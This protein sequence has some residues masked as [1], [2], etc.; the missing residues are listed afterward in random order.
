MNQP[1]I[2]TELRPMPRLIDILLTLFAWVLFI[3][4]IYSGLA[5]ALEHTI[6]SEIRPFFMTLDTMT[7]YTVVALFNGIVLIGWAKYNQYRFRVERRHR[8]PGLEE[9]ELA[10]SL[11]IS[12]KLTHELGMA[13]VVTVFHDDNGDIDHIERVKVILDNLLPPPMKV[14][15]LES[16]LRNEHQQAVV[17]HAE[18]RAD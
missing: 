2:F 17:L 18:W 8:R 3:W 15:R 6:L 11:H 10:S 7:I 9:P 16:G 12:E 5:L 14:M 13:R 1:L 4:L